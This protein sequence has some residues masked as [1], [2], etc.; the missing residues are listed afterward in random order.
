M[1]TKTKKKSGEIIFSVAPLSQSGCFL[2]QR[3]ARVLCNVGKC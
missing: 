2:A 1:V 3:V